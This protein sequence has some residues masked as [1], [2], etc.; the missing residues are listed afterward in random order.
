MSTYP[1]PAQNPIPPDL[2]GLQLLLFN[3]IMQ[4]LNCHL[5]GTIAAVYAGPPLSVDVSIVTAPTY[6]GVSVPYPLFSQV[7]VL[8][9]NG[10]GG[11]LTFPVAKGDICLLLFNDQ[12]LDIWWQSQQ[13]GLSPNSNRRHHLSDA[14]ALVGILPTT[15][16]SP[17]DTQLIGPG[18]VTLSLGAK[19]KLSNSS[20]DLLTAVNALFSALLGW[21]D[22]NGDSPNPATVS[23]L[24]SAKTQ[25]SNLLKT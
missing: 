13:A 6:N 15:T 17:T 3:E 12:D 25:F 22:T 24:N 20:A 9:L 4:G 1:I 14:V 18:P 21:V 11:K 7:P 19:A 16:A 5:V 2:R 8:M 10:G 23:A